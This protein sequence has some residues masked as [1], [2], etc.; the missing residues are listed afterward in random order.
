MS[1]DARTWRRAEADA[2]AAAVEWWN[3]LDD[4]DRETC[5]PDEA[6][7]EYADG[8]SDV[9][10]TH[11]ART[12]WMDSSE[13]RRWE[14]EADG[15]LGGSEESGDIDRRITLCVYFAVRF[16]F[17]SMAAALFDEWEQAGDEEEVA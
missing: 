17:E 8:C 3:E 16:A 9:I 10:Y 7:H 1:D 14:D 6:A 2:W 5:E 15:M 13:V 11:N 12:I 4:H